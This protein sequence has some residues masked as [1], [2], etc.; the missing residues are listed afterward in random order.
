MRWIQG[1]IFFILLLFLNACSVRKMQALKTAQPDTNSPDYAQLQYWAAHPGKWDPSDSIPAPLRAKHH[2]DSSVHVFFVHPTTYTS[3]HDSSDNASLLDQ[4]LNT[5]TDGSSILYQASVFNQYPVFAPRYRQAHL[6]NY[7]V[8]DTLRAIAAFDLAYADVRAAFLYYWKNENWGKP[9][10]IAS[11]SQGTTHAIR[12]IQE[13]FDGK[14]ARTQLVAAYLICMHMPAERFQQLPACRDSLST[15]CVLG[16]RTYQMDY[17]PPF[18]QKERDSSLVVNPLNWRMDFSYVPNRESKG[19]VLRNFNKVLPRAVDAQ[20]QGKVL[21]I[22]K[23][24]VPG[25][26]LL[27]MKNYH[28]GDLNLFYVDIRENVEARVRAYRAAYAN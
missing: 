25:K 15:G 28:I 27:R 18:V 23:P 17:L 5:K 1:T 3:K 8:E 22:H 26:I 13:F 9:I 16:W 21:W 6:R 19:A 11:H 24:D 14:P 12:L 4:A 20:V 2:F 7:Y 10:V